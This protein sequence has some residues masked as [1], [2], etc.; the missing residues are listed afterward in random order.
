MKKPEPFRALPAA[1]WTLAVLVVTTAVQLAYT[2]YYLR[3]T[4]ART[5]IEAAGN[6]GDL[7]AISAV[8]AM[9]AGL[10]A[11]FTLVLEQNI[12]LAEQFPVTVERRAMLRWLA[13]ALAVCVA[14]GA[15]TW[16]VLSRV[17]SPLDIERYR[18]ATA[19]SLLWVQA[20]LVAPAFEE[21]LFRGFLLPPLAASRLR[22]AGAIAIAAVAP[23]LIHLHDDP[24]QVGSLVVL[25]FFL[26]AAR[27]RTGSLAAPI[28][29]HVLA[30]LLA[31]MAVARVA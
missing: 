11:L 7:A 16:L 23:A 25:G 27:L 8:I 15:A 31:M 3:A 30:N 14:I 26:G 17:A 24:W 22:A 12:R 4:G 13:I 19:T 29:M 1:G 9:A 6:D 10:L 18:S 21:A 5:S 20:V 2:D 28:A